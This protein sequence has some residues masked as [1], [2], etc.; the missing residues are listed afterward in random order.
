M[1]KIM[2]GLSVIYSITVASFV[3]YSIYTQQVDLAILGSLI[4]GAGILN[5]G[6]LY[7]FM[8]NENLAKKWESMQ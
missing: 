4:L 1:I 3:G 8:I 5:C 7:G 6:N 2:F